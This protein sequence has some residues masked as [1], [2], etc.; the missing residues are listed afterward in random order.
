M[1]AAAA[2]AAQSFVVAP[3]PEDEMRI[4]IWHRDSRQGR[5]GGG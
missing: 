3:W 2:A 5:W 4:S 1:G